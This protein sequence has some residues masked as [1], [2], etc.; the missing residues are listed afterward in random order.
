MLSAGCADPFGP[1]A[2]RAAMGSTFRVPL[3]DFEIRP[4]SVAL[5]ADG[6]ELLDDI[7]LERYPNFVLGAEREGLPND[8]L[9][10]CDVRATIPVSGVDSLNV[11]MA[12][13]LALYERS[14]QSRPRP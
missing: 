1:K 8:V 11:A 13:T 14:R 5:V 9:E 2:L 7:D 3:L 4:A 10:R 6:G 12:G